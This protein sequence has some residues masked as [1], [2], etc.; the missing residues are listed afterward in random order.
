MTINCD[1]VNHDY[2]KIYECLIF[3]IFIDYI[4]KKCAYRRA[5]CPPAPPT[6]TL[7]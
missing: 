3:A 1:N 7:L 5:H 2:D 6:H 4:W